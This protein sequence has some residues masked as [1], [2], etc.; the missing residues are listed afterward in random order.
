MQ[1]GLITTKT[2]KHPYE[3]K[4]PLIAVMVTLFVLAIVL[5][6]LLK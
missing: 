4:L 6:P 3:N 5:A 1:K 2:R